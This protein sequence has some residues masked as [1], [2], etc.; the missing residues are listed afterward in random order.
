VSEAGGDEAREVE[1]EFYYAIPPEGWTCFHCGEI[2]KTP[3]SAR[4]HFGFDPSSDPA[5]RIKVGEERGLVMELR[6][7]EA[8][9][10]R[11]LEETSDESGAVAREFYGLD[12]KHAGELRRAEDE[13]YR[14]G[15]RDGRNERPE[16]EGRNVILEIP[17]ISAKL[18]TGEAAA[19]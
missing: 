4:D 19:G 1:H 16:I 10:I 15:L 14:K 6:R 5:C 18:D 17:P 12:A 9:Y 3:G 13:G 11:L 8:K 7:V 2:F